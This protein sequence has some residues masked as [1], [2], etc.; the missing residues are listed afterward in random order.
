MSW[1][2]S[3]CAQLGARLIT[4]AGIREWHGNAATVFTYGGPDERIE[5]DSL[6]LST[7]NVSDTAVSDGLHARRISPITPSAIRVAAR[8]AVMAIYEGRK[9]GMGL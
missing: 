3:A 5:A 9:L 8:T 7:T 4:E 6:V 1:R 2:A